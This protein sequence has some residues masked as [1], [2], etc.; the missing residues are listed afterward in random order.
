MSTNITILK[1]EDPYHFWGREVPG[2][3]MSEETIKFQG[4]IGEI[5]D[6]CSSDQYVMEYI[7]D[8]VKGKIYLAQRLSDGVWYRVRVLNNLQTSN[9]IK[10]NC[11]MVDYGEPILVP[12]S[13]LK[14]I[15]A[16]LKAFPVQAKPFRLHGVQPTTLNVDLE[17]NV[18]ELSPCQKWDIAAVE[19]FN[20]LIQ[21]KSAQ[22]DIHGI[23]RRETRFVTLYINTQ[24]GQVNVNEELVSQKFAVRDE[25]DFD[26]V[27]EIGSSEGAPS[28]PVTP[29]TYTPQ[30]TSPRK[31][32][33]GN[34]DSKG[35]AARAQQD[36]AVGNA[37]RLLP[38]RQTTKSLSSE[39]ASVSPPNRRSPGVTVDRADEIRRHVG[40]GA[41]QDVCPSSG[42]EKTSPSI[43]K[44]QRMGADHSK[45]ES[46]VMTQGTNTEGESTTS[47]IRK[48][49]NLQRLMVKS[50]S[51]AN[52]PQ[53]SEV[54]DSS[55][56]EAP[57]SQKS[58]VQD[59]DGVSAS[60]EPS[61]KPSVPSLPLRLPFIKAPVVRPKEKTPLQGVLPPER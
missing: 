9:G 40:R 51:P 44:V 35:L 39:G 59:H 42:D 30:I 4:L 53:P 60:P 10:S 27:S 45:E 1:S 25:R 47:N 8:P 20:K 5:Q 58:R 14:D 7:S 36:G 21:G 31:E 2:P 19:F 32:E 57:Q 61:S 3:G 50:P 6:Y 34:L 17:E 48:S 38:W 26:E 41:P 52:S 29:R 54:S 12:I 55:P 15:P 23:G 16:K 46:S 18:A 22:V 11:L 37:S 28:R 13:R 33:S 24:L 43:H 56:Q 49:D